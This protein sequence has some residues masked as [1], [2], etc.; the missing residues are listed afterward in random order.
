MSAISDSTYFK[1][2]ITQL[3]I[4]ESTLTFSRKWVQISDE[5]GT[6]GKIQSIKTDH[7][8][9]YQILEPDLESNIKIHYFN[10][11]GQP[12]RWKSDEQK[13][14]KDFIRI[15][16]AQ[17]K[18][19]QKYHQDKGSPQ[20][21]FFPPEI[22][23]KYQAAKYHSE[24]GNTGNN[25]VGKI[26]TLFL[27]E[28][29]FKALKG[30]LCGIDIIG[31]PSIHG[32]YNGDI[33]GR[34]HEDIQDLLITCGVERVA[35]LV[36]A[37]LISIKW[38]EGKDLATRPESFYGSV[39]SFRESLQNLI[40]SDKAKLHLV[41]FMYVHPKYMNDAK[42]LD[43]LLCKYA[44][45]QVEIVEDLYSLSGALKHFKGWQIN[46]L[47]KDVIGR[48][49]KELGLID[50]QEFYKTYQDFI[51]A[52]EFKYKRR[53]Y[54]YN[55]EKKEVVFVRHEDADKFMRIGPDWVKVITK[56]N[57]YGETEEEIV[58]WKI[59]EI[60]RD[61]KR[62]PDFLD[63]IMKY[64][65]FCNEPAFNQ[66][67]K[68]VHHGCFN[69]CAPLTW[70]PKPGSIQTSIKFLKHIFQGKSTVI[71]DDEGKPVNELLTLGDPFAVALDWLSIMLQYPKQ[72]LPV[73]M[74]VSKE[75]N[76]GKSTFL[77]F[78]QL[79]FKSNMAVLNNELFKMRFNGHYITKF[80]IAI[81]EGFLDV[82]K[83]AEKERLK[84]LVTSD[85]AY[86]EHKGMNVRKINFY[87]KVIICSND[88]D[89]V[90]KID[91][92]ESR[93]FVVKVPVV[94]DDQKD[95]DLELKLKAEVE[96]FIHFLLSRQIFHPRKDRLWFKAEW[97]ITDQ[98]RTI[99][100]E[101]KNRIDKVF[102]E[103]IREQ[104]ALYGLDQLEYPMKNIVE[105]L[106]DLKVS[107]YKVDSVDVKAYLKSKGMA[108]PGGPK[109]VKIPVGFLN[110]GSIVAQGAPEL[111]GQP[112]IEFKK[113]T[114]RPYIFLKS[115][116]MP[117]EKIVIENCK[118]CSEI[119]TGSEKSKTVNSNEKEDVPF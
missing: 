41:Y 70:S 103:W 2:R 59:S 115:D 8:K 30:S 94:S 96:A 33:K 85:S 64:D 46:D 55:E 84:Q 88:A 90:M 42:G 97:F 67:Y 38:A 106:N 69:L 10:L 100:A 78:L 82:D 92:G 50:E 114:A 4:D 20:F 22:I 75:N 16:L 49:R 57:K 95:P 26:N 86:L 27:V 13:M 80:I 112:E 65:D 71:L 74:L 52:R 77:K 81:D 28:G 87:S 24:E 23:K 72:M 17:P 9:D 12:Y 44:E 89:K 117:S 43:D 108:E 34:L 40:D 1:Q 15:R 21:P 53:R 73:P 31:L 58:P 91:E 111:S 51:G 37:D 19:D 105:Q 7:T 29:E 104:F 68:R 6:D 35:F 5:V 99:I 39:K 107:K 119:E 101:T 61:Y 79:I 18:G 45:K 62:Y 60:T 48:L 47:N 109:Q 116:W 66:S 102:E 14:S 54:I 36:D 93:W 11:Q 113:Y 56:L 63:Q 110:D 83:K 98:M 3:A 25:E 32:F 118:N 76:T